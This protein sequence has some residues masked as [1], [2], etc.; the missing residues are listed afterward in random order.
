MV[1]KTVGHYRILDLLG[2]GG[3][4]VVWKARDEHLERFVALKFLPPDKTRDAERRRRFVREAK[5]ASALD[6][7]NIVTVYDVSQEDGADFIVM[8]YLPG[9]T[10]RQSI[11]AEGLDWK[12]ALKYA[13][14]IAAALAAAHRVGIVHRD[15]KPANIMVTDEGLVKVLDF[16]LAKLTEAPTSDPDQPTRTI[17]PPTEEGQILG[18]V[19]YMSPEQVEGKRLDARSDVFSFGAVLHEMLSGRPAFIRDS[20]A[21]TLSAILGDS[22]PPVSALRGKPARGVQ[23]IID[24]CLEKAPERRYPSAVELHLDLAAC[25][26][27]VTAAAVGMRAV[28]RRPGLVIPAAAVLLGLLGAGAWAWSRSARVSWAINTALPEIEALAAQRDYAAAFGLVKK[29]ERVIPGNAQLAELSRS[30]SA[31]LSVDVN[32]PAADVQFKEYLALDEEWQGLGRSPIK[33][34]WIPRGLKR[35]KISKPGFRTVEAARAPETDG[36]LLTFVLDE[37][38]DL[39]KDMV[40]VPAATGSAFLFLTGLDHLP[41][42]ALSDFLID[43]HEVTNRQYAA[44]VAAGGYRRPEFWKQPFVKAGRTLSWQEGTAQFRDSTGQP[45][46]ATWEAGTYPSGQEEFP[47]TGVSWYE[48]A[49]YAE[50]AGKSLPSIFHWNR[51]AWTVAGFRD[52]SPVVRLSNFAGQAAGR[53]GRFTGL[54][55]YGTYDLAGNV[56]EWC[57]NAA[58]RAGGR[59]YILGGAWNEPVYM[60]ND[61]DAQPPMSRLPTYGFRCVKYQSAVPDRLLD[62]AETARRD[63]ANERAIDDG[64]FDMCRRFYSYDRGRLEPVVEPADTTSEYWTVERA[65][66]NTAYGDERLTIYLFLPRTGKPPYQTVV[67]FPGSSA[68]R[69]R[70]F[71]RSAQ[72][73]TFD[74]VVRSGRAV[75]YPVYKSTYDRGDGLLSDRPNL[76]SSYRDHVIQWVKDFARTVDYLETRS[77]LDT[78][79]LGYYGY[80][81]GAVMGPMVLAL[82]QRVSVAVL[83]CG[84]F[85]QQKGQP[86]AEQLN[87]AARVKVPVL[88]LN[89]R[90][91]F[92]F[93]VETSQKPMFEAMRTAASDKRHLLFESG[94]SLPRRELV[95]ETLRWF[96]RYLGAVQ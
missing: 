7:P 75:A 40:R 38:T 63:F 12:T 69:S 43:T 17:E 93:P 44:F 46:P 51:A 57:W 90:Y 25:E 19:G 60:F 94:H 23:R 80:S 4:G 65:T 89:G 2:E 9:K 45:G 81:W 59:R 42:P 96:D 83:A 24:R 71:E 74:F 39:P 86:E 30:V 18:T 76:S 87:F 20:Q 28:V 84:G 36:P 53:A 95:T 77:D 13:G 85:W 54:N 68:L 15:L 10:L 66:V 78:Q 6:H 55:P 64:A 37:A 82:D 41:A 34:A 56:K 5:S 52:I 1:G 50:F 35:W 67:F 72:T 29:A 33:D 3:M 62:A 61:P 8:E 47:V 73:A 11:P 48:A 92:V 88:M 26:E 32:V 58:D 91:D 27:Q 14:G 16:G 22:P 49:A 79:R 31:Q 70:S 21:S